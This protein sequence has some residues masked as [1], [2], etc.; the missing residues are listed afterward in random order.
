MCFF[1]ELKSLERSE[2]VKIIL[3]EGKL[4]TNLS[5]KQY[6]LLSFITIETIC[7]KA[8][9]IAYNPNNKVVLKKC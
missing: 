2:E 5:V 7:V 8:K 1:K 4:N 3:K 9:G 6:L